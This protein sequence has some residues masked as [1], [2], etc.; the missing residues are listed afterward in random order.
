MLLSS[1]HVLHLFQFVRNMECL[2]RNGPFSQFLNSMCATSLSSCYK[3]IDFIGGPSV[4]QRNDVRQYLRFHNEYAITNSVPIQ[5]KC[6]SHLW[7]NG[8]FSIGVCAWL[9]DMCM[10]YSKLVRIFNVKFPTPMWARYLFL[11]TQEMEMS[12]F[13]PW[14]RSF[15]ATLQLVYLLNKWFIT[16]KR[17]DLAI[18][19][20]L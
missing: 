17:R 11:C 10:R 4:N 1:L 9:D 14:C 8:R 20:S 6:Y 16:D 7:I 5:W 2:S 19:E 18:L 12:F 3:L 15:F 13:R